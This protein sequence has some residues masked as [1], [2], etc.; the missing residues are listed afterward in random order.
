MTTQPTKLSHDQITAL[1]DRVKAGEM[2]SALA[3]EYGISRQTLYH[4]A[5]DV[6][7][8][9]PS[10]YQSPPKL[11]QDQA[12]ELVRRLAAGQ[13][14]REV[15]RAFGICESTSYRYTRQEVAHE[16]RA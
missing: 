13:T 14:R 10:R 7:A 1:R 6:A 3:R 12:D 11:T 15:S 2:R 4:Y 5:G 16:R 8:V 9:H